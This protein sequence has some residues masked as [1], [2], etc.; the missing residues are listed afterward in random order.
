M[1]LSIVNAVL[2]SHEIV[3]RH[4]EYYKKMVLPSEV[5]W[6]IV[7]DGS[8][9]KI[10]VP[11]ARIYYTNDT[12]S[13]TQPAARNLGA[14]QALGEF[15]LFTDIDH[16]I[17]KETVEVAL[18]NT[19]YDVIRFRREIGV[20]DENGDFTQDWEVLREWGYDR[21]GLSIRPHG[22]SYIMRTGLYLGLGG[23]SEVHVGT[24]KYPNREEVPLKRELK[25][26]EAEGRIKIWQDKTKPLI[27]MFPNGWYCNNGDKDYN[28]FGLFHNTT[29][30]IRVSRRRQEHARLER[31]RSRKE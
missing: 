10:E 31:D 11:S 3:R 29:R 15:C 27:Y 18:N 22:N 28:P 8:D 2:N 30:S 20:L 12:R 1:K 6:I 21:G 9:Q 14:K 4:F 17:P 26:L 16:I 25:K 13:W 24:G 7:D 5:E 19:E 23:V